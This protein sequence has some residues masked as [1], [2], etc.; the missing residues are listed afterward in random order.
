MKQLPNFYGRLLILFKSGENI[1]EILFRADVALLYQTHYRQCGGQGFGQRR[2]VKYGFRSHQASGKQI[3][4]SIG[5]MTDVGTL[6]GD[7]QHRAWKDTVGYCLSHEFVNPGHVGLFLISWI[8]SVVWF[9]HAE[10]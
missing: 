4:K 3:G 10:L 7:Q 6:L 2:Q 1:A 9:V 8:L 5:F